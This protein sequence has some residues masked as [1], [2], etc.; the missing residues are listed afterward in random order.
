MKVTK[1]LLIV[2]VLNLL[3]WFMNVAAYFYEYKWPDQI[4]LT[5]CLVVAYLI[6]RRLKVRRSLPNALVFIMIISAT[7][8]IYSGV[9][10]AIQ[11]T[12]HAWVLPNL[13]VGLIG[14]M[15]GM[16]K[17]QEDKLAYFLLVTLL[18]WLVPFQFEEDQR[19]YY[20]RL[21]KSLETRHGKI[22]Q[23]SW[24]GEQWIHYNNRLSAATIDAHMYY[25]PL[26][27]P[28]MS[29]V[30][31]KPSVL[32]I[33]GDNGFAFREVAKY[34]P[35][36]FHMIPLDVEVLELPEGNGVQILTDD[37]FRWLSNAN[38]KYDVIL[39]DLPD[40]IN[41]H[42]NQ[43]YTVEFYRACLAS[44]QPNGV[45]ASQALSPYFQT[46]HHLTI[47]ETMRSAGFDVVNFHNQ[48]PTI[49]QWGWV[50]GS[51]NMQ[52]LK[53]RLQHVNPTVPTKWWSREAM[54]MMLSFGKTSYFPEAEIKVNTIANPSL[55]GPTQPLF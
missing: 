30:P 35:R 32:L 27:H 11:Q 45:L 14:M 19:L 24:K 50:I 1:L 47:L 22:H 52:D 10:A 49:G 12:D 8:L 17:L 21:T 33:G 26:V 39:V 53:D 51:P 20:D 5:L 29:L 31:E 7:F 42:I 13:L 4:S 16:A 9:S 44:L 38:L 28:A 48:V 34:D 2:S 55:M 6:G 46:G 54:N 43:Y 18:V 15:V 41:V 25:E 23:V 37:P 40:P 3:L 36:V